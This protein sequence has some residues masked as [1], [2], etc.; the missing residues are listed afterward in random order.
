MV[1]WITWQSKN[2][3]N[4]SDIS[5]CITH[6]SVSK[7]TC[8]HKLDNLFQNP[9]SFKSQSWDFLDFIFCMLWSAEYSSSFTPW[10]RLSSLWTTW[11][12]WRY[13][14]RHTAVTHLLSWDS[15]PSKNSGFLTYNNPHNLT[16]I[17]VHE[18]MCYVSTPPALRPLNN[19]LCAKYIPNPHFSRFLLPLGASHHH[20]LTLTTHSA[21]LLLVLLW[22]TTYQSEPQQKQIR[23]DQSFPRSKFFLLLMSSKASQ[24]LSSQ[25]ILTCN[26]GMQDSVLVQEEDPELKHKPVSFSSVS[27]LCSGWLTGNLTNQALS[28]SL[29]ICA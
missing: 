23:S 8:S 13:L 27:L 7:G 18:N 5:K 24:W 29:F 6:V 20:S 2:Q 15:P 28:L 16:N 14:R 12:T 26:A 25:E 4:K 21:S 22:F 11:I 17:N 9:I 10:I 1:I 3:K 19:F